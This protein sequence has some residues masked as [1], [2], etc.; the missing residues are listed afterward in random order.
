MNARA[1]FVIHK[2]RDRIINNMHAMPNGYTIRA[3]SVVARSVLI[4]GPWP[5]FD[6]KVKS[7]GA[8]VYELRK[9]PK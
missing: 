1:V 3:V 7:L 8:G 2:E 5:Y 9:V 6:I 4:K